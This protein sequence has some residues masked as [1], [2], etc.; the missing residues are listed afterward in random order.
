[1]NDELGIADEGQERL[2]LFSEQ[3][4]VGQEFVSQSVNVLRAGRHDHFRIEIGVERVAG[5]HHVD[6]LDASDFD[7]AMAGQWVEAGGLGVENDF[8][9]RAF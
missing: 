2:D 9:H 7:H 3:R 6:E 4:L 5:R 1:M 8:A